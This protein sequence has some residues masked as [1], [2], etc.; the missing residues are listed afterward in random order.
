LNNNRFAVSQQTLVSN[1]DDYSFIPVGDKLLYNNSQEQN[2]YATQWSS[3]KWLLTGTCTY[4][5]DKAG[6]NY[7][8]TA[9]YYDDKGR[10]VQTRSS[11]KLG[12]YDIAYNQYDFTGKVLKRY[13]EHNIANND[14]TIVA[15]TYTFLWLDRTVKNEHL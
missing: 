12:G 11:N 5:L 10:V 1:Y 8:A 9:L 15:E 7:L 6:T 4:I 3:P 13:K 14:N 2:G